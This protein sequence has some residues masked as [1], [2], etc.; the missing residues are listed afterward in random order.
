MGAGALTV[1]ESVR[2]ARGAG[3][4][5]LAAG[6]GGL[7]AGAMTTCGDG[8]LVRSVWAPVRM[9]MTDGS[10]LMAAGWV[11]YPNKFLTVLHPCADYSG[12]TPAGEIHWHLLLLL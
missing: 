5:A 12:T 1:L 2:Q 8:R 3:R 4:W 7:G 9:V 6:W 10:W 11:P